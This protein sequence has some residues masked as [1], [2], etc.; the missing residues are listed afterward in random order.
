MS[1]TLK[2]R[3]QLILIDTD[4]RILEISE[5]KESKL[6]ESDH[7]IGKETDV[8]TTMM[9]YIIDQS[10]DRYSSAMKSIIYTA[11]TV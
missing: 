6:V 7:I 5:L 8:C 2:R 1:S 11:S 9:Y 10:I 4:Y 3:D